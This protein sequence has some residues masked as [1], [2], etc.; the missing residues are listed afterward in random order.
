M[1]LINA[2]QAILQA[3]IAQHTRPKLTEA[4][5]TAQINTTAKIGHLLEVG[6]VLAKVDSLGGVLT[7]WLYVGYG[8]LALGKYW[9]QVLNAQWKQFFLN[10]QSIGENRA[11]LNSLLYLQPFI[12]L[13]SVS[14]IRNGR[15]QIK[16]TELENLAGIGAG[17]WHRIKPYA[18]ALDSILKDWS[19]E[20]LP[21]IQNWINKKTDY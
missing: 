21:Q 3:T 9:R 10:H 18:N 16:I 17:N 20:A 4:R 14:R 13:N 12:L 15:D 2:E 19:N 1:R 11:L 5:G 6:Q 8:E 7:A